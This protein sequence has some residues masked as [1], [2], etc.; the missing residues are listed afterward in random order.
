MI[1]SFVYGMSVDGDN[2]TDRVAEAKRLKANFENGINTIIISPRRMGKTSLVKKVMNS[3]SDDRVKVVYMDVYDCRSEY[4]FYNRFASIILKETAGKMDNVLS[5]VKQFLERVT[6]K[7][8]FST[9]VEQEFS[10]SLGITPQQYSPDELLNLPE[11][12]AREKGLHIV[13][14]IDEFQ[15]IG[16]FPDSINVQKR[17]R[18]IWQ[19]QHDVSYCMFGSKR[20]LMTNIFQSRSMPFFQFGDVIYLDKIPVSDW[21]MYIKSRFARSGKQI[22][23]TLAMRI[24]N[25][26][27]CHSSYVQQ[28]AWNVFVESDKVTTDADVDNGITTLLSQSTPLFEKQIE[29]LT[30][31]QMNMLRALCNGIEAD[32]GSKEVSL[33][34]DLGTKSNI[35]RVKESLVNREL[36]DSSRERTTIVDPV[37]KLWFRLRYL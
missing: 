4:D 37:F 36:I 2:F 24:C 23:D 17:M 16:E 14:C 30:T 15:Q 32:F 10:L 26:V 35:V 33:T 12:I 29:S 18:G 11:V 34:Y 21:V 9:D 7:I 19:H 3:M 27:E 22:D 13:V 31:Y 25:V 5:T 6:P 1:K 20:H 8:V 28:L